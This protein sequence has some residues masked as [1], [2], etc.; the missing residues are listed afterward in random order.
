MRNKIEAR[1]RKKNTA[2]FHLYVE[3]KK[4]KFI[5]VES[6]IVVKQGEERWGK[7]GDVGQEVQSCNY[8]AR[9]SSRDIRSNMM[10]IVNKTVFYTG[11]L[12]TE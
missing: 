11:N 1:H 12:L 2:W 3:S 6:C 5:K 10:I 9:I 4:V 7:W 8:V